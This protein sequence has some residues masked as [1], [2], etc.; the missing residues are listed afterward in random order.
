VGEH[1]SS[2]LAVTMRHHEEMKATAKERVAVLAYFEVQMGGDPVV[3]L[4]KVA[5]ERVGANVHDIWDVHCES[6][7][8]WAVSC[9]LNSYSQEDFKSR[10]VVLTFHIGLMAR[11]FTRVQI[12]ITEDAAALLPNAWRLW[13][14]AVEAM[15]SSR[16][17]EDFQAVGV[18]LRECLV[19]FAAESAD[20][21][22]VPKGTEPPKKADVV[23]WSNL[24]IDRL[25]SGSSREQLRSYLKKL[26]RET[27]DYVSKLTHAKNAVGYDAEIGTAAVS[28]FLST[29]TAARVR[30]AAGDPQRCETCGSYRVATGTC[31]RCA[32][33]DPD[34]QDPPP[35]EIREEELAARLAEPCTPSSDISTFISPD[36]YS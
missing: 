15:T 2:N 14:Q 35:R 33:S 18:R 32:W 23:G 6:S 28:H 7:R 5:V 10:D 36:D 12:P 1:P 29:V 3:H 34:Y 22:L 9:P 8:W 13:E 25:A 27:W 31:L 30:W 26:I 19:S 24:L 16:E 21:D 11:V 4:E 20:A 17:A